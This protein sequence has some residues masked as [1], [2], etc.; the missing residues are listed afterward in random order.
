MVL[1][2]TLTGAMVETFLWSPLPLNELISLQPDSSPP[3]CSY[4]KSGNS[5]KMRFEIVIIAENLV[6]ERVEKCLFKNIL[7]PGWAIQKAVNSQV[8]L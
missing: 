8:I 5:A 6:L 7:G 1:S 4:I 3:K 2:E